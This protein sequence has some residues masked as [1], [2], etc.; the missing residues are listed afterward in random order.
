VYD[1]LISRGRD[2]GIRNAGY[3]ALRA[4]RIEKFFAYWGLDINPDTTPFEVGRDFRVK[5]DVSNWVCFFCI[6][7]IFRCKR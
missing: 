7:A 1:S 5:F 4:L 3:Y 6:F 2:Y